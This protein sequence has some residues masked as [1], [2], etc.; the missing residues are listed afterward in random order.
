VQAAR[1]AGGEIIHD[2]YFV[3]PAQ[4]C[5]GKV[6]A[7]KTGTASHNYAHDI[8]SCL[9]SLDSFLLSRGTARIN[10]YIMHQTG[11]TFPNPLGRNKQKQPN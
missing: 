3:A 6:R 1:P 10:K 5:V 7:D 4:Q 11:I 8:T 9:G 2:P